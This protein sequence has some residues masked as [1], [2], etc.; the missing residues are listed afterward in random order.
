MLNKV[1]AKITNS[2]INRKAANRNL[3]PLEL[4]L[5]FPEAAPFS[6]TGGL[7]EVGEGLPKALAELGHKVILHIPKHTGSIENALKRNMIPEFFNPKIQHQIGGKVHEADIYEIKV[8]PGLDVHLYDTKKF[9]FFGGRTYGTPY[10]YE[11]DVKRFYYF[12]LIAA[13]MIAR[14]KMETGNKNI[15]AH[16]HDWQAAHT[17]TLL[18]SQFAHANVPGFHTIHNLKYYNDISL[19]NFFVMSGITDADSPGLYTEDGLKVPLTDAANPS[20]AA[21]MMADHVKTVSPNYVQEVISSDYFGYRFVDVLKKRYEDGTFTGTINGVAQEWYPKYNHSNFMEPKAQ[22]KANLQNFLGLKKDPDAFLL[23]MAARFDS[24]K[25]FPILNSIMEE[26]HTEH[27]INL[28][29]MINASIG[30]DQG[31]NIV[32]E[33]DRLN[34]QSTINGRIGML[35]PYDRL[36]TEQ[37]YRAGDVGI[38]PSRFEP[39][40]L[41]APTC[42]VNG[43]FPIGRK[44]G[45]IADIIQHGVN[46]RHFEGMWYDKVGDDRFNLLRDRLMKQV[47]HTHKIF[48]NKDTWNDLISQMMKNENLSW[49][50]PAEAHVEEYRETISKFQKVGHYKAFGHF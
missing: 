37:I 50:V 17:M 24:Q 23:M 47:I 19:H 7:G 1:I 8:I 13:E 32:N 20:Y 27:K 16:T 45:G 6:Q 12:N 46:G 30:V 18:K 43:T 4:H 28:Q 36:L 49:R 48:Q 40:G 38:I 25:G 9:D 29:F 11:D 15:I 3:K 2:I 31:Q 41:V 42:I 33:L 34:H 10:S 44:I 5:I 21:F 14:R 39:C 22:E 26:L 35:V